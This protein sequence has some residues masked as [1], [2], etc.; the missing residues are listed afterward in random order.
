MPNKAAPD[1]PTIADYTP[2]D[3]TIVGS[4]DHMVGVR[5]ID[6]AITPV[7]PLPNLV[8]LAPTLPSPK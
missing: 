1:T 2:V 6:P 7:G 8:T 4:L 5:S 3:G